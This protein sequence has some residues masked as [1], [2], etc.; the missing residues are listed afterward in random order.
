[1]IEKVYIVAYSEGLYEDYCKYNIFATGSKVKATEYRDK[2]NKL[3]KKW[4]EYYTIYGEEKLGRLYLKEEY[5]EK[6][7]DRWY[8][9]MDIHECF[10]EELEIR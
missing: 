9:I 6:Y 7:F 10:I 3:L 4:Q 8:K 1:M 2:F 5:V